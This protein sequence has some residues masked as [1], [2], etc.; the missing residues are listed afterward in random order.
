MHAGIVYS[1]TGYDIT[2]YFQSA[3]I[4]VRKTAENAASDGCGSNFS[5][6]AFYLP[7]QLVGVIKIFPVPYFQSF[8]TQVS[9]G[10]RDV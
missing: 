10:L 3:F 9:G 4:E 8:S 5:G 6:T 7:H 2:I 1:Q